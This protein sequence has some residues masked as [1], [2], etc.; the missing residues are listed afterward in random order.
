MR[1]CDSQSMQRRSWLK[2]GVAGA[3]VLAVGGGAVAVFEPGLRDG[4]LSPAGRTV[5]AGVAGGLLDGTLPAERAARRLA[6]DG[7]LDRID[8]LAAGLAPHA[9]AE[10]SQLLALLATGAGRR[11]LAGLAEPWNDASVQDIQGALQ[12]MRFSS[13]GLRQQAYHALHDI[14]GSAYFS[15][16]STWPQ[17]GYPGPLKL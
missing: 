2:L 17:L 13:L 12:T 14:A 15:D 11:S 8:G 3:A 6:I 7:M 4:R 9:Q 16:A 5:F 1:P 10:L